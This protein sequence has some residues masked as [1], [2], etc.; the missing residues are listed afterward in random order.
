VKAAE[1]EMKEMKE[2]KKNGTSDESGTKGTALLARTE[3]TSRPLEAQVADLKDKLE[4]VQR[5]KED[6]DRYVPKEYQTDAVKAWKRKV[7]RLEAEVK[8]AEDEMKDVKQE[9]EKKEEENA[10]ALDRHDATSSKGHSS[11]SN[12]M[13]TS[14]DAGADRYWGSVGVCFCATVSVL[15]LFVALRRRSVD[16]DQRPLLG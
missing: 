2:E 9:Q 11:L 14:V 12:M 10:K 6:I 15:S 8:A 1:D 4:H 5:R 3:L 7:D 13:A 16:V